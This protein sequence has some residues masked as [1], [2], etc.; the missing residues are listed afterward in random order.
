MDCEREK[1]EVDPRKARAKVWRPELHLYIYI[2]LCRQQREVEWDT[3]N[4]K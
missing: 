1:G 4:V 3:E 2:C